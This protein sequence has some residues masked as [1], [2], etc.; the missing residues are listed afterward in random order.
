MKSIS[1][2]LSKEHQLLCFFPFWSFLVCSLF[3]WINF[4]LVWRI[5]NTLDEK[6]FLCNFESLNGFDKKNTVQMFGKSGEIY[7]QKNFFLAWLYQHC[8]SVFLALSIRNIVCI[9]QVKFIVIQLVNG[10]GKTSVEVY[11]KFWWK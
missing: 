3:C 11:K 8:H 5:E 1:V 4:L 2:I 10:K 7:T 9:F 6:N